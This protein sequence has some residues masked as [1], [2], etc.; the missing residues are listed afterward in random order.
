MKMENL[1]SDASKR[2]NGQAVATPKHPPVYIPKPVLIDTPKPL[3]FNTPKPL[4]FNTSKP[5]PVHTP[6]AQYSSPKPL[7]VDTPPSF[8][9]L[10]NTNC[11]S[12]YCNYHT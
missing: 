4:L 10:M 7:P 1:L 11:I 12:L 2:L 6:K 8:F 9:I 5:L 3:P